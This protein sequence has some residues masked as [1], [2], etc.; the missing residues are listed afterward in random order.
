MILLSLILKYFLCLIQNIFLTEWNPKKCRIFW[1]II[2]FVVYLWC[3]G[4]YF[5]FWLHQGPG[6]LLLLFGLLILNVAV[7]WFHRFLV[8]CIVENTSTNAISNNSAQNCEDDR[9]QD[10]LPKRWFK[11]F[12]YVLAILDVNFASI[13]RK[14][15]VR[16]VSIL[17]CVIVWK[18]DSCGQQTPCRCSRYHLK[19]LGHWNFL[20]FARRYAILIFCVLI[21][22]VLQIFNNLCSNKSTDATTIEWQDIESIIFAGN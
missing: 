16:S 13:L 6:F 15:Q 19:Q 5:L 20:I 11:G 8:L 22:L 17:C 7:E 3:G 9:S 14:K 4:I 2:V 18:N 1:I 10:H 12:E 21:C